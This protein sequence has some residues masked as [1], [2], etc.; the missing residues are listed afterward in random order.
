VN[1]LSTRRRRTAFSLRDP[2]RK[3][4]L[5]ALLDATG[6]AGLADT[7]AAAGLKHCSLFFGDDATLLREEAPWLVELPASRIGDWSEVIRRA[8]FGHA[9]FL[10]VT[11]A[12]LDDLRRHWKKW[13]SVHIPGEEGLVLFRFF[14]TRIALVFLGTVGAADAQAFFGPNDRFFLPQ[15]GALVEVQPAIPVPPTRLG[16]GRVYEMTPAQMEAF[17]GVAADAFF[18]RFRRYM[19]DIWHDETAGMDDAALNTMAD[20]AISRAQELGI[21]P[22][23]NVVVDLAVIEMVA[24]EIGADADFYIDQVKE[25]VA[26]GGYT[27]VLLVVATAQM[28]QERAEMVM[29]RAA[30]WTSYE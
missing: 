27:N 14:D 30:Y 12:G 3:G 25:K 5:F 4:R 9:G 24:P 11:D 15:G 17:S 13:L 19:R 2:M 6:F 1:A 8:R 28:S 26:P 18:D 22:E 23:A 29:A 10:C 7:L 21:T 20:R 16:A